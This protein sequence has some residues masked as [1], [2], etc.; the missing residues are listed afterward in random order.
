M[1]IA[2]LSGMAVWGTLRGLGPFVRESP[3]ESLLLLQA[4]MV[5]MA[6]MAVPLAAVVA[7]RQRAEAA[8]GRVAALVRSSDDAILG[9]TVDGVI[10]HWNPGAERLYGY[11]AEEAIGQSVSL[12]IPPELPDELSKVLGQIRRGERVDRYETVRMRKDGRRIEVSVTVSPVRDRAGRIVG[13]SSIGRD[14]TERREVEAA[15]HERDIVRSVAS[16]AAAAAH[17]INNPLAILV[18]QL[19]LLA[20]EVPVSCRRRIDESLA[21]A[22]RIYEIVGRLQHVRRIALLAPRSNLD[23]MLDIRRSSAPAEGEDRTAEGEGAGPAGNP[24]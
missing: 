16:L 6:A 24:A 23:A 21:A 4:Y 5:T 8:L 14:I 17:E 10:T 13:A 18:G 22:R 12:I 15:R 11:A 1:A 7:E 2:L 3:N 19:Q 9:K 20:K